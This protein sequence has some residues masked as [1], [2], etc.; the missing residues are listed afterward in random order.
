M[1]AQKTAH[2]FGTG[3][4]SSDRERWAAVEV[5]I[6]AHQSTWMSAGNENWLTGVN[7][8]ADGGGRKIWERKEN[9]CCCLMCRAPTASELAVSAD[10]SVRRVLRTGLQDRESFEAKLGHIARKRKGKTCDLSWS[11]SNSL[12]GKL[13][14]KW[15]SVEINITQTLVMSGSLK[16]ACVPEC[17]KD[18]CQQLAAWQ[19][20][21]T[22]KKETELCFYVFFSLFLV[23]SAW[24]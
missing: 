10:K 14:G 18:E 19:T 9:D 22:Q 13:W 16:C 6:I 7:K 24:S 17:V 23:M 4:A 15:E 21:G 12:F 8:D 3:T 1:K 5:V 11:W 20:T 2:S